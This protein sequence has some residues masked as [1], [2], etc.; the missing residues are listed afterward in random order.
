M[1]TFSTHDGLEPTKPEQKSPRSN[2]RNEQAFRKRGI[3]IVK[4]VVPLTLQPVP[5][6]NVLL[7]TPVRQTEEGWW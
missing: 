1:S 2:I 3:S 6:S 5:G 4:P 7:S